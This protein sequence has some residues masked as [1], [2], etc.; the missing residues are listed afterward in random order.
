MI[1]DVILIAD[2][3][4]QPDLLAWECLSAL[5]E[6]VGMTNMERVKHTVGVDSKRDIFTLYRHIYFFIYYSLNKTP[7]IYIRKNLCHVKH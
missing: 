6:Q 7:S 4:N 2:T 1:L 5:F 3:C